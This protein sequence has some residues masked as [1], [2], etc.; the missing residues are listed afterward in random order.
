MDIVRI[1]D[2]DGKCGQKK[3]YFYTSN[4]C[5]FE[6]ELISHRRS[7][8]HRLDIFRRMPLS[9]ACSSLGLEISREALTYGWINHPGMLAPHLFTWA[10][11]S[12]RSVEITFHNLTDISDC[13]RTEEEISSIRV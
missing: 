8:M 6:A 12:D 5:D 10:F 11:L 7:L 4:Q 1:I 2:S 3:I 13:Y 9:E